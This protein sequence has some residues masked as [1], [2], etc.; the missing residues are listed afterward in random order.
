MQLA[1]RI[2][3]TNALACHTSPGSGADTFL[4]VSC[5][6]FICANRERQQCTVTANKIR[7][8]LSAG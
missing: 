6:L 7:R 3:E 1:Q 5:S 8:Y 2:L 4:D